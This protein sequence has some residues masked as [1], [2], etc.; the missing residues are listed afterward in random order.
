MK[1]FIIKIEFI[2][3]IAFFFYFLYNRFGNKPFLFPNFWDSL[4]DSIWKL[5]L[6]SILIVLLPLC[7]S[8]ATEIFFIGAIIILF[9]FIIFSLMMINRNKAEVSTYCNS[10]FIENFIAITIIL[11]LAA[12]LIAFKVQK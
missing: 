4:Y 12:V 9:E 8:L 6:L 7:Y 10:H 11:V 5:A 1:P 3:A 2:L